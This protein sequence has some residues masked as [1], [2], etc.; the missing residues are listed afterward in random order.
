MTAAAMNQPEMIRALLERRADPSV[1]TPDGFT[2]LDYAC[3]QGYAAVADL[4]K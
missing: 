2:A 1:K 4:L 3:K